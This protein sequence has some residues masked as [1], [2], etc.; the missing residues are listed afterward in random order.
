MRVMDSTRGA[1][2]VLTAALA[3]AVLTA[4]PWAPAAR[5]QV[6]VTKAGGAKSA[7][8]WSG[9]AA[10]GDASARLF[11]DTARRDLERSGWFETAAPGQGRYRLSGTAAGGGTLRVECRVFD[12]TAGA[13]VFGKSYAQPEAR[14]RALAHAVADDIVK[15]L[16][17]R[18][19][20]ASAR[21]AVV[22]NGTGKK[23]IYLC[24]SD[25]QNLQQLTRDRSISLYPRFSPDG[26]QIAYT[27]YMK[28]FPDVFRIDL[29]SGRRD[30][31]AGYPG[32]NASACFSPDGRS[33]AL[34]LS[35]DGNPE[36]YV[37]NLSSGGLT[38][39]T[40][41][42]RAA[43]SSPS[44]SPDGGR[45][46]YVSDMAGSPQLYVVSR[47]GGA[48]RRLTSRGS[49]NV[50][51]NWGPTGLIAFS[52]RAGGTYRICVSDDAGADIKTLPL[53]YASWEDPCW[54]PDG[55]HLACVRSQGFRAAIYLVDIMGDE[56]VLLVS[57][58]GDWYSPYWSR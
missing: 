51:P 20:F 53:D 49:E 38:R 6:V 37:K 8:D 56:P 47:T 52:S 34:I 12:A 45:L 21:L 15:A 3:A 2:R 14:A 5:A 18:P 31:I 13:Q 22:G 32:L 54:A 9:F 16:T 1:R 25:G 57:G 23:E 19:G 28:G 11:Q 55:R 4:G 58:N 46:V 44:W 29:A 48:P 17:G 33:V 43:E 35:K 39:V 50:A 30:R 24:D 42:P 41:T 36:L 40:D 26:G 10:G 7:V 27:S